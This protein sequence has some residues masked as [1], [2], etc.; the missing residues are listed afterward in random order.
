MLADHA[1]DAPGIL[2]QLLS[3]NNGNW[4]GEPPTWSERILRT[5]AQI[6]REN[7]HRGRGSLTTQKGG[8]PPRGVEVGGDE[9]VVSRHCC[10]P[11]TTMI[12]TNRVASEIKGKSIAF[13]TKARTIHARGF[14]L[15]WR[16]PLYWSYPSAESGGAY[17]GTSGTNFPTPSGNPG[18]ANDEPTDRDAAG[19]YCDAKQEHGIPYRVEPPPMQM[20]PSR[21]ESC[22]SDA[23]GGGNVPWE[24]WQ[25]EELKELRDFEIPK[26]FQ[27]DQ[28]ATLRGSPGRGHAPRASSGLLA[29]LVLP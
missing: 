28:N 8:L 4:S 17:C 24:S 7:E 3:E 14:Q 18:S 20:D 26:A 29:F 6:R 15:P 22:P 23:I 21:L 27:C 11:Q 10:T 1:M 19:A 16:N 2:G 5:R 25:K 12:A 9:V 13:A